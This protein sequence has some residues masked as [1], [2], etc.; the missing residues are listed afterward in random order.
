[1]QA[2]R[3]EAAEPADGRSRKNRSRRSRG[4]SAALGPSGE[5]GA[6]PTQSDA[7]LS[8]AAELYAPF[9]IDIVKQ[10]LKMI[11]FMKTIS[12]AAALVTLLGVLV[13]ELYISATG[14][15]YGTMILNADNIL[16]CG[17][18]QESDLRQAGVLLRVYLLDARY[19]K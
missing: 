8:F 13:N 15:S 17:G 5:P 12:F 6:A 11:R 16:Y 18:S 10:D 14:G 7:L 3:A 9:S 1:M 2:R 19:R 4:L